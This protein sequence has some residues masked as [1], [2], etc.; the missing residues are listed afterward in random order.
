MTELLLRP[1]RSTDAGKAGAILSKFVKDTAWMPRIHT[2][3]EDIGFVGSMI[4]KG[5]VTV[6]VQGDKFAG[7]LA[8]DMGEL[9]ALYIRRSAWR[10]GCGAALLRHAQG[11]S[12]KLSLWTFQANIDAQAFYLAHGFAEVERTNGDGNDEHLPDIRF[13]WHKETS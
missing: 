13:E 5:W 8:C 1:A 7:F 9:H 10:Q 2:G 12:K 11:V 3:A 4:E 6:A